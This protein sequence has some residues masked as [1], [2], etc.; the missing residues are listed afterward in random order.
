MD[1]HINFAAGEVFQQL[2]SSCLRHF[3]R[4]FSHLD[5]TKM[6]QEQ[7][8]PVS[9][10]ARVGEQESRTVFELFHQVVDHQGLQSWRALDIVLRQF[11]GSGVLSDKMMGTTSVVH[12]IT[13]RD[14]RGEQF[15]LEES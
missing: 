7:T 9:S 10:G 1:L 14:D 8:E 5:V 2:V 12:C 6:F 13:S 3:G 4:A 15:G 11:G